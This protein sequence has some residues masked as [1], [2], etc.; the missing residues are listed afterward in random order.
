MFQFPGLPPGAYV[1]GSGWPACS[2]PGS[3]IRKS[4]DQSSRPA[5]PGLSQV[6]ASFVAIR[7]QGIRRAPHQ[8]PSRL[9][10]TFV[11]SVLAI[12]FYLG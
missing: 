11:S 7:L 2:G 12:R 10:G 3:P 9:S 6:V 1:F 5:P 8:L 4:R